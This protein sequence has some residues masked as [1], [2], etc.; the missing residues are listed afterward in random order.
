MTLYAFEVSLNDFYKRPRSIYPEPLS[1]D[2]NN[3]ALGIVIDEAIFYPEQPKKLTREH[4]VSLI[5]LIYILHQNG[6][7]VRFNSEVRN[8]FLYTKTAVFLRPDLILVENDNGNPKENDLD[9]NSRVFTSCDFN[10]QGP[11]FDPL[12]HAIRKK[13]AIQTSVLKTDG[14]RC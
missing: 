7:K 9:P 13:W 14:C 11:Q 1:L 6:L 3:G 2:Y 8:L 4:L 10:L 12:S 5:R